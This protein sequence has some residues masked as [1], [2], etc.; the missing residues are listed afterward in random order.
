MCGDRTTDRVILRGTLIGTRESDSGDLHTQ[1]QAWV[2]ESPTVEVN[3]IPLQIVPCSTYLGGEASCDIQEPNST[4][5]T[6][7][8]VV[9]QTEASSA[10]LGGVTLYA[11]VGGGVALVLIVV[12]VIGVLVVVIRKRR[13]SKKYETNRLGSIH[14]P[15]YWSL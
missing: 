4:A 12:L 13:R 11:A 6:F 15:I 10:A 9:D 7:V 2:D 14:T 3:G 8:R 5:T 1:L